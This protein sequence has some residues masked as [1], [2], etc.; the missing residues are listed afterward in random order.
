LVLP[1]YHLGI[2]AS[3]TGVCAPALPGPDLAVCVC[4]CLFAPAAWPFPAVS[5]RASSPSPRENSTCDSRFHFRFAR[6][7]QSN[8]KLTL[9][10]AGWPGSVPTG[11]CHQSA[12]RCLQ[13][14]VMLAVRTDVARL[15]IRPC[16]RRHRFRESRKAAALHSKCGNLNCDN[17]NR[18][19][20][21]SV[22][23]TQSRSR[24]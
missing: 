16:A 4:P 19:S 7:I 23:V 5:P 11:Q 10:H 24:Q 18:G 1:L 14:T 9:F 6:S 20:K 2:R 17:L 22:V 15:E 8:P 13:V 21:L 3:Q 12:R